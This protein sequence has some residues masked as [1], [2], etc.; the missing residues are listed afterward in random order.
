MTLIPPLPSDPQPGPEAT[1]MSRQR[2]W[3]INRQAAGLC[4]KCSHPALPGITQCQTHH[5]ADK[6]RARDR[7]WTGGDKAKKAKAYARAAKAIKAKR[8]KAST[9]NP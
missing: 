1:A 6:A 8:N 4:T 5:D 3:Q 2:R 7:Y 9:I